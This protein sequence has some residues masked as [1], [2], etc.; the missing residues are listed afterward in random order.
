MRLAL[1]AR[2]ST[3]DQKPRAQLAALRDYATRRKADAVEFVDRG[4]SGAK[5]RRLPLTGCLRPLGD[6]RSTPSSAPSSIAWPGACATSLSWPPSSR[7][8]A[9]L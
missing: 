1:Y 7:P 9:S 6:E 4:V 5:E 3:T 8:S 2:V